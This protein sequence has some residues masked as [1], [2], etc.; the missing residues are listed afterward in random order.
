MK[1]INGMMLCK[2]WESAIF[3]LPLNM[4][5]Y[6]VLMNRVNRFA[7]FIRAMAIIMFT[8]FA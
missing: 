8:H 7:L 5:N 6:A 3:I 4:L 1:K 2:Q